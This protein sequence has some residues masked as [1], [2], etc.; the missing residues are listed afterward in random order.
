MGTYEA[1]LT[2]LFFTFALLLL[3]SGV[4]TYWRARS[5]EE[6]SY[7]EALQHAA[8]PLLFGVML[9]LSALW[10]LTR[11]GWLMLIVSLVAAAAIGLSI[12]GSLGGFLPKH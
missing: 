11:A 5:A 12:G 6:R 1:V 7:K 8:L 3:I 10:I 2:V 9:L 4:R